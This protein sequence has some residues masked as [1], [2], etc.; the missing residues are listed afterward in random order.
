MAGLAFPRADFVDKTL[1]G[2]FCNLRLHRET[3]VTGSNLM[4]IIHLFKTI[5]HRMEML[6]FHQITVLVLAIVAV[7]FVC[8]RGYGSR[9]NY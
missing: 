1:G 3:P 4:W 9:S 8:M 5:L 7:G 2:A 6:D